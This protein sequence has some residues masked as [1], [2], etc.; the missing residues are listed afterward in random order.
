MVVLAQADVP[1]AIAEA[2]RNGRLGV[3]DYYRLQNIQADTGMPSAIAGDGS[4]QG[5]AP[6]LTQHSAVPGR[7]PGRGAI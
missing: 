1:E 7:G 2:F 6:G 3:M 4:G 5:P